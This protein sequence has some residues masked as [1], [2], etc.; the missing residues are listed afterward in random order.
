MPRFRIVVTEEQLQKALGVLI[1][2]YGFS[3]DRA[4]EMVMNLFP[5]IDEWEGTRYYTRYE[6]ARG[7]EIFELKSKYRTIFGEGVDIQKVP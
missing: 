6:I 4:L 3:H 5:H 7:E 1:F 2:L